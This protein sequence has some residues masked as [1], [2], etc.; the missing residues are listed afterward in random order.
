MTRQWVMGAALSLLASSARAET[1]VLAER[2]WKLKCQ[3][4]HGD[5]GKGL[6]TAGMEAGV[7]DMTSSEWQR[8]TSDVL[9]RQT[10]QNGSK[11]NRK[12]KSFRFELSSREIEGL[13]KLIRTMPL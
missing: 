4:C 6:T 11:E 8:R 9:I 5:D 10:I 1:T 2:V 13:V 3:R 12:M 7:L